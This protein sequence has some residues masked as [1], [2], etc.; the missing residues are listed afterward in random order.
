MH[1]FIEFLHVSIE[2]D[3]YILRN[4]GTER[5]ASVQNQSSS[6]DAV[7]I[8]IMQSDGRIKTLKCCIINF[9]VLRAII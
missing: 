8:Q 7:R 4:G 5:E 3:S 9:H 1:K 2:V 6:R